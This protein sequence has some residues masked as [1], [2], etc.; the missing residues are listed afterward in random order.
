MDNRPEIRALAKAIEAQNALNHIAAVKHK[1]FLKQR[2]GLLLGY[3]IVRWLPLGVA[4]CALGLLLR[5]GIQLNYLDIRAVL[6]V[7]A[8]TSIVLVAYYFVFSRTGL[9]TGRSRRADRSRSELD[10]HVY[11]MLDADD[12]G[13]SLDDIAMTSSV[14]TT[15]RHL[16]DF[17][18][19]PERYQRL[20]GQ[21][22]GGLV[23]SGPAGS[24]KSHLMRAI[25]NTAKVPFLYCHAAQLLDSR[26]WRSA[27]RIAELFDH[28]GQRAPCIVAVEDID[29]LCRHPALHPTT[30]EV[31][32]E[33][34]SASFL[35]HLTQHDAGI[36]HLATTRR[37]DVLD[38]A[39]YHPGRYSSILELS[40]SDLDHMQ[41]CVEIH[42]QSIKVDAEVDVVEI[43]RECIAAGVF[44]G[45]AVREILRRATTM[46]ASLDSDVVTLEHMRDEI[47][48]FAGQKPHHIRDVAATE[49]T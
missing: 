48:K 33:S 46:A 24:G 17:L 8:S 10:Q 45:A 49:S 28:A 36:I 41:R 16:I 1:S 12:G 43:A 2:R 40:I 18:E 27:D 15:V 20:G 29:Q 22:P 39:T 47:A 26:G 30:A 35:Y 31:E 37:P 3:T 14:D 38:P 19:N 32:R 13:E 11:R 23:L 4:V 42:L 44:A 6:E 25:A 7:T 5:I 21:I 9:L 34:A